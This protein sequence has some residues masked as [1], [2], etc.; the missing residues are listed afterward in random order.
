[1]ASPNSTTSRQGT[2]PLSRNFCLI[3]GSKWAIFV[4]IF[5]CSGKRWGTSPMPPPLKYAIGPVY[6]ITLNSVLITFCHVCRNEAVAQQQSTSRHRMTNSLGAPVG[7]ACRVTWYRS[8]AVSAR[9]WREML[10]RCEA[11]C[12]QRTD[13]RCTLM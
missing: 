3:F 2:V 8:R 1:M 13:T 7:V 11:T 5:L 12:C 6:F 4:Q 9:W 10:T